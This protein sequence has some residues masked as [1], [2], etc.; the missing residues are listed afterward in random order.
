MSKF[1]IISV[2]GSI[3]IPQTGFNLN[4][5]KNFKQLILNEVKKG[6]RFI[7]VIGGGYTCR[8]YQQAAQKITSLTNEELDWLG[9]DSTI[10]NANFV[11]YIFKGYTYKKV[12]QDPTKKIKT[13]KPIIVASGWKPG[14]STDKDAVLQAK[15]YGAKEVINLSNIE[16]V[17]NK[18][19]R[20]FKDAQKIEKISWKDFRQNIVGYKWQAGKNLPFDP[21]ASQLAEKLDL[22][23]KILQGT[24]LLEVKNVLEGKKF[25]GTLITNKI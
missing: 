22:E 12:I 8:L 9:I 2:G 18:D 5:L 21:I 15:T 7:L 10:F 24:D 4:F 25:K 20:K 17:Y 11:K 3:I 16:Y 14:C 1:K 6:Y 19:P 23:V 13:T